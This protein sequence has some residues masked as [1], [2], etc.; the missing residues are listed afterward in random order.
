MKKPLG[1]GTLPV[2]VIDFV[3]DEES[4]ARL[5]D[6]RRRDLAT[7]GAAVARLEA[8]PGWGTLQEA[9]EALPAAT[10]VDLALLLLREDAAPGR[11]HLVSA[12]GLSGRELGRLAF[13][14]L[15]L[16]QARTVVASAA[17]N[18]LSLELGIRWA[19][20]LLL[21]HGAS[22]G[23]LFVGARTRRVPL[24]GDVRALREVADAL[25]P[26]LARLDRRPTRLR[27]RAAALARQTGLNGGTGLGD[28]RAR[29][30]QILELYGDGLS[31]VEIAELLVISPHTV[32]TH[33]RN[34]LRRLEVHSRED[35]V[36]RL[37]EWQVL[38]VIDAPA[39]RRS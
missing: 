22:V 30:V 11:L 3:L 20:G 12:S 29:E 14:P 24:P 2:A 10:S 16:A 21:R 33:V 7:L 35:A 5:L 8:E 32:R 38:R 6:A 27:R 25:G 39:R 34:A 17:G 15:T 13:E 28:L 1:A 37:Q 23:M 18:L 4:T 31:T 19:K 26:A 9:A 36:A